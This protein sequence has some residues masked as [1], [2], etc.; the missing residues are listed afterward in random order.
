[1]I[2]MT[3]KKKSFLKAICELAY[4]LLEPNIFVLYVSQKKK[5]RRRKE[6]RKG[7]KRDPVF[8]YETWNHFLQSRGLRR[9]QAFMTMQQSAGPHSSLPQDWSQEQLQNF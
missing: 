6:R 8:K 2:Q 4:G 3:K 7:R 9:G 1:M 5:R